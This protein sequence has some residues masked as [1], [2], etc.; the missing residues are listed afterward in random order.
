M[1][2]NPPPDLPG[3]PTAWIRDIGQ[4]LWFQ[5]RKV[6]LLGSFGLLLLVLGLVPV[7]GSAVALVGGAALGTL[8]VFLDILEPSLERAGRP[9]MSERASPCIGAPLPSCFTLAA[10]CLVLNGIPLLSLLSV[11]VCVAAGTLFYCERCRGHL[12]APG[13]AAASAAGRG[14]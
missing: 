6:L 10:T 1:T 11:P 7:L 2:G 13:N 12:I 4:A 14:A 3:G 8:T 9:G 5:A